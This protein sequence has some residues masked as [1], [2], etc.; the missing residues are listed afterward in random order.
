V[1]GSASNRVLRTSL[2]A[3]ALASLGLVAAATAGAVTITSWTGGKAAVPQVVTA[4]GNCPGTVVTIN[5]SGF[6]SDGGTP[7]VTIGG[8]PAAEVIVGSDTTLFA[9]VGAGAQTGSLSVTTP[10][11]TATSPVQVIVYPCQSTAAATTAPQIAVVRPLKRKG[12]KNVTLIGSGFVGTTSVTVGGIKAAYAIPSDGLM[13]VTIPTS[14]KNG[15]LEIDVT[16]NKGTAKA[17]V[18]KTG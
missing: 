6:V 4:S 12:G 10:K 11:G 1:R 17:T 3:A 13:Y 8:V 9:R 5:G 15:K 18:T 16:N 14:A 2:C 7:T